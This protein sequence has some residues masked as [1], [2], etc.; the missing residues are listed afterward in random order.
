MAI[1]AF[2][3]FKGGG[4]AAQPLNGETQDKAMK[5]Y[6][7]TPFDIS[8]W[9]FGISQTVN[10]GSATGGAGAG[11]VSFDPFVIKKVVDQSSPSFFSTLATGGHYQCV[12]LLLRKSGSVKDKSGGIYL[13]FNFYMAFITKIDWSHDDTAPTE[14]IT[15]DYGALQVSYKMQKPSGE[16]D[17]SIKQAAWNKLKNT[18][19]WP[20]ESGQAKPVMG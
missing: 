1:D 3:Q 13:E 19:V 18:N 16:L 20:T 8:E 5:T 12:N 15:F 2:V 7:P 4:I 14:E 10:I 6:S 11:K 17:S 9:S